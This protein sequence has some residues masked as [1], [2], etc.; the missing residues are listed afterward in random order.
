MS[1]FRMALRVTMMMFGLVGGGLLLYYL[2]ESIQE[3]GLKG[4][5]N[6]ILLVIPPNKIFTTGTP[7]THIYMSHISHFVGE[8]SSIQY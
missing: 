5:L 4:A 3:Y 8:S 7:H 2:R 6:Y 1:S